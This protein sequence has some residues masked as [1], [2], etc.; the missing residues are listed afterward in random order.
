MHVY[1]IDI[2]IRKYHR[3]FRYR[4]GKGYVFINKDSNPEDCLCH[5]T[6]VVGIL[7]GT[8]YDVPKKV[9]LHSV[10]VFGCSRGGL[11]SD[12]LAGLD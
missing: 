3:E 8:Q 12:I 7:G 2:G 1:I 5:G 10:K 9:T 4:I 6:H 11:L